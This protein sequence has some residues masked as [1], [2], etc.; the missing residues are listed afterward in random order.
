[1]ERKRIFFAA[2]AFIMGMAIVSG[3]DSSEIKLPVFKPSSKAYGTIFA[4]YHLSYIGDSLAENTLELERAYIGY[5]AKMSAEW[6]ADV[7][8]DVGIDPSSKARDMYLKEAKLIYTKGQV[9]ISGGMLGLLQHKMQE[10]YWGRRYVYRSFQEA[11]KISHSADIG[12]IAEYYFPHGISA[13]YTIRNGEGYKNIQQDF[14]FKQQLGLSYKLGKI[15]VIRGFSCYMPDTLIAHSDKNKSEWTYGFFAGLK[16]QKF[17]AG[18]EYTQMINS[19]NTHNS[20][21]GGYSVYASAAVLK[22]I[23]IFARFDD[24]NYFSPS[25]GDKKYD[26]LKSNYFSAGGIEYLPFKNIRMAANYQFSKL[27]SK[28]AENLH[29]AYLNL[30]VKF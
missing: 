20:T 22:K 30:E 15:A 24:A 1:M 28:P 9:K 10:D 14:V 7:K 23:N 27:K 4:N 17:T 12:V 2:C 16:L 18:A 11:Q 6:S 5:G 8:I 19:N 13:D 29:A 21:R 3:Q 26:A 25:G